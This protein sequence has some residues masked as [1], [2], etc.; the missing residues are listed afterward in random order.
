MDRGSRLR[1]FLRRLVGE[2][3]PSR[4]GFSLW[5]RGSSARSRKNRS[6]DPIRTMVARRTGFGTRNWPRSLHRRWADGSRPGE[7]STWNDHARYLLVP[8]RSHFE[9]SACAVIS[10][11]QIRRS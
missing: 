8:A 11:E 7:R 3:A 2:I 1:S 10:E 4:S 5:W 6:S 9:R